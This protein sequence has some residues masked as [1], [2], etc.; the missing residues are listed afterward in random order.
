MKTGLLDDQQGE[1]PIFCVSKNYSREF[2]EKKTALPVNN[3]YDI[4]TLTK[5]LL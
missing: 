3:G 5:R 2:L 1:L 4:F